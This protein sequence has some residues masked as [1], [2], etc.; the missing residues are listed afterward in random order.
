MSLQAKRSR[1]G[2]LARRHLPT[3]V[4]TLLVAVLLVTPGDS[5]PDPGL[6]SWLDKPVHALLFAVHTAL[7]VRSCRWG[8]SPGRNLATAAAVSA[9]YAALLEVV[10]LGVPGR[11][12][13]VWD[14]GADLIGIALVVL[15]IARRRARLRAPY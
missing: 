6:W 15:V 1:G 3:L 10:Q 13:A 12:L 9:G 7:L 11:S 4:W 2:W 8:E 5:L 14:L